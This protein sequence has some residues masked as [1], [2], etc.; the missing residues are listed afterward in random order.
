M[1]WS[2]QKNDIFFQRAQNW[3]AADLPIADFVH[4]TTPSYRKI[5][6]RFAEAIDGD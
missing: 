3:A 6:E 4:F 5:G 1:A 2:P